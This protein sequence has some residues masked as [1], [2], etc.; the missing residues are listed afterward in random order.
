M[1]QPEAEPVELA[2]VKT[3]L[4]LADNRDDALLEPV[5][6]AV[7]VFLRRTEKARKLGL[8]DPEPE[9]NAWPADIVQG[10]IM[11]AARLHRRKNSPTGVEAFAVTG[12]VYV[13]R[14]DPDIAMMLDLD[15]PMVG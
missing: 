5:I 10:G 8:I 15:A 14:N 11:L 12:P 6:A 13:R 4:S 2:A 9:P 3:Y 7:N 1:P